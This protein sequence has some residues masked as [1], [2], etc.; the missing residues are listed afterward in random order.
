MKLQMPLSAL[1]AVLFSSLFT[2]VAYADDRSV[3]VLDDC[4]SRLTNPN[5]I[6][7]V[8]QLKSWGASDAEVVLWLSDPLAR[9]FVQT[10]IDVNYW[11]EH[12]PREV[13]DSFSHF[14]FPLA[15]RDD[16]VQSLRNIGRRSDIID[17]SVMLNVEPTDLEFSY[18]RFASMAEYLTE[19]YRPWVALISDQP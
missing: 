11:I 17:L 16:Q 1:G 19:K 2:V 5:S 12:T 9:S 18:R 6:T 3:P 8:D 10:A 14:R 13:F 15:F 7:A 4:A